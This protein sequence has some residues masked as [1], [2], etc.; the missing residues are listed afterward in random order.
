MFSMGRQGKA[1]KVNPVDV[2][3]LCGTLEKKLRTQLRLGKD[4]TSYHLDF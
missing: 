3:T 1:E 2:T 4:Y